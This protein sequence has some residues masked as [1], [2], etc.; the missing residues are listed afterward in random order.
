MLTTILQSPIFQIIVATLIFGSLLTATA[1]FYLIRV[2]RRYNLAQSWEIVLLKLRVPK[3]STGVEKISDPRE[4][5]KIYAGKAEQFFASIYAIYEKGLRRLILGQDYLTLEIVASKNEI[6]FYIGC[7]KSLVSLIQK[8]IHSFW[9]E[10]QLEIAKDYNIFCPSCSTASS[11]LTLAKKFIYPIK[12]YKQLDSE[13]LSAIT[14]TF[15]NLQENEGAAIQILIRPLSTGWHRVSRSTAKA[16]KEGK[17]TKLFWGVGGIS[18]AL[19]G[20]VRPQEPATKPV[21]EIKPLTPAQEAEIEAIETK[22]SKVG[23]E[24]IIRIVASS[25]DPQRPGVILE[26]VTSPFSQFH[27]PNF[28]RFKVKKAKKKSEVIDPFIFRLFDRKAMILNTEELASIFHPPNRLVET[29]NINWL[30]SRKAAP[31]TT[32]PE[33]GLM[34]GEAVFRGITKPVR[35]KRADR[36]RHIYILGK[37]GTG[38]TTLL[39]YMIVQDIKN[40]EGLCVIDPHGDLAEKLLTKI[41]QERIKDVIYFDPSDIKHPLGLNLFE[42]EREDQK[43]FLISEAINMFY[44][45][46]DPHHTGIV[47]PRFERWFRNAAL[48]AMADPQGAVLFDPVKIFIDNDFLKE[49]LK[50]VKELTVQ[51]FWQ[52]EM[53]QTSE[54]HKSEVLGWFTAKFDAFMTDTMMRNIL[55]QTKSA[56]DF[57]EIMDSGK[58]LIVNLS[59]G[60]LGEMNQ[61]LLGM[62]FVIRIQAAAMSR[63]DIPEKERRDFYLYVD[64]FQNFA[65]DSFA[66]TLSEARKYRLSLITANQYIA[67]LPE[68]IREAIFGNVGTMMCFVMGPDDAE[69]LVKE[70]APVLTTEDLVNMDRFHTATKLLIDNT[71]SKPFTMRTILDTTPQNSQTAELIKEFTRTRYSRPKAVVEQEIVERLSIKPEEKDLS[72]EFEEILKEEK[73]E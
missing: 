43:H 60:K 28:N 14:N 37:T 7:P 25:P 59:K 40:G 23:F 27:H 4:E 22:A 44:K 52:K 36:R 32:L 13:A 11:Y 53:A 45:L 33:E 54:F 26:D 48:T 55:G 42:Y 61:R 5:A 20:I 69:F 64:E 62:I 65:V 67:Q 24:T 47:G 73:E 41:P 10:A 66:A 1:R 63:V 19:W 15:S 57:R 71:T 39:E 17:K 58:I 46:Y 16:L 8:Q 9:P 34:L 68:I 31:P 21:E 51:D 70:F 18:K 38:K 12:T 49:K 56:F 35:I 3:E 29:P 2:V 6:N 72:K 50:Y 30:W